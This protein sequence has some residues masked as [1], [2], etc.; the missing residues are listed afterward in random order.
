MD[1]FTPAPD[2]FFL[3]KVKLHIDG[4]QNIDNLI[5]SC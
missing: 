2:F 3:M 4:E 1:A 5:L